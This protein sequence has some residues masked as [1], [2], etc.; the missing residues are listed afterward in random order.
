MSGTEEEDQGA[1]TGFLSPASAIVPLITDQLEVAQLSVK[2]VVDKLGFPAYAEV[3]ESPNV[4]PAL[5]DAHAALSLALK[6]LKGVDDDGGDGG[7]K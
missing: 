2:K 4:L 6:E 7:G 1:S 5:R 3:I